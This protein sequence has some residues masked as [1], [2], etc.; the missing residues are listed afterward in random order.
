MPASILRWK[1]GSGGDMILHI[2]SE[3]HTIANAKYLEISA[4]G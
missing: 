1:G 4:D 2:V 3:T